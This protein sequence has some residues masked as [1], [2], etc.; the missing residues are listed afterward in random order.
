M[1]RIDPLY[2]TWILT[3]TGSALAVTGVL[4]DQPP[5]VEAGATCFAASFFALAN[6]SL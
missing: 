2:A 1:K 3:L 5:L 4:L 6:I